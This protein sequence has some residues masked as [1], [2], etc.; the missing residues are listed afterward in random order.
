MMGKLAERIALSGVAMLLAAAPSVALAAEEGDA[1]M[2]QF[3]STTFA[4]QLFWLFVTLVVFYL[5]LRNVAL[6]RIGGALED[7]RGK[8]DGDLEKAAAHREDAEAAMAAYEKALA[9]AASEAQSMQRAAAQ[10]IAAAAAERGA[11]L[12][13]RLADD[14][15]AAETRIAA[16]KEPV[17]ADLPD[18][19]AE[20][21]Q[22]AGAR[23]AGLKVSK[24]DA[25]AAVKAA[26]KEIGA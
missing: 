17:L 22:D 9:E 26:M 15:R 20:V 13:A 2:P 16:A 18:I 8:I 6:P 19:A 23:L 12:A 25:E 11:A 24:S 14:T 3:D 4:S 10:D 7:R 1:G 5:V 21:V